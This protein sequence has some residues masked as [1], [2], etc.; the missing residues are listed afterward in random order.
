MSWIVLAAGLGVANFIAVALLFRRLRRNLNRQLR[1]MRA[2]HNSELILHALRDV[3]QEQEQAAQV[4][5]GSGGG[6][7]PFPGGPQ[8]ARRKRHLALFLGS[9]VA[10]LIAT[11]TAIVREAWRTQ[12]AQLIATAGAVVAA[13]A[14]AAILLIASPWDNGNDRP[15]SSAPTTAPTPPP[16]DT[17]TP[18]GSPAPGTPAPSVSPSPST[19]RPEG[20]GTAAPSGSGSAQYTATAPRS[21]DVQ[22][23]G[24]TASPPSRSTGGP[25]QG[26]GP[27]SSGRPDPPSATPTGPPPTGE[28]PPPPHAPAHCTGITVTPVLSVGLCLLGRG[29]G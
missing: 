21:P 19:S 12:P 15:P 3:P 13:G 26:G 23:P 18:T 28:Q 27:S 1:D 24:Q 6:A 9:G 7:E 11:L 10:A 29:G 20:N 5:N 4:A 16:A 22:P 25:P 2:E 17:P 14:A 8:P